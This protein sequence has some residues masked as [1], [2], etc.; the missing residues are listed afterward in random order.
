MPYH[1][2][3]VAGLNINLFGTT[4][5][6][7]LCGLTAERAELAAKSGYEAIIQ[8]LKEKVLESIVYHKYDEFST[9]R[10]AKKIG[11]PSKVA[12][13]LSQYA[14]ELNDKDY[15]AENYLEQLK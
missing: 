7:L 13:D 4:F 15:S 3:K 9:Y 1:S 5:G 10:Y 14:K 11:L 2:L 12:W 8:R 6:N